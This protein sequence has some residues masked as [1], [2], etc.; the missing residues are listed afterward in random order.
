MLQGQPRS[1]TAPGRLE[2]P[3]EGTTLR[4]KWG[5]LSQKGRDWRDHSAP[6][7]PGRR[8]GSGHWFPA[9]RR[10]GRDALVRPDE[11]GFRKRGRDAGRACQ[12]QRCGVS[13]VNALRHC[14]GERKAWVS[15][16]GRERPGG[17]RIGELRLRAAFQSYATRDYVPIRPLPASP[18][19]PFL[20]GE[21]RWDVIRPRGTLSATY[22]HTFGAGADARR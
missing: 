13:E 2:E 3:G 14:G 10:A 7:R 9:G 6:K 11:R 20:C 12:E 21:P 15:C 8:R 16:R 5:V 17:S 1:S 22:G 18:L 19:P 4:A